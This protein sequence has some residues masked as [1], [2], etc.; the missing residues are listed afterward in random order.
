M[1]TQITA[2][3]I[4]YARNAKTGAGPKINIEH[5]KISSQPT[6][7]VPN[8][9]TLDFPAGEVVYTATSSQLQ[10]AIS[11]NNTV[12]YVLT[13]DESVGPFL[14][15]RIGL[16]TSDGVL[17][18]ITTISATAEYKYK[19]SGNVLGNRL[20]YSIYLS[21]TGLP[22]ICNFT[23]ALL[24]LV[25]VPEVANESLLPDPS[26]VA[27][28]TCQIDRHSIARIPAIALRQGFN[29][30]RDVPAWL[31]ASERRI[32]GQGEGVIPVNAN[33][34]N[35][36]ATVGT[37]VCI[38]Q[39]G[40]QFII[41]DPNV[42]NF[43]V[44]IRSSLEE[45]T[46]YGMYVDP[47]NTYSTLQL[48]Y[49]GAGPN[50]GRI[51]ASPNDWCI[52]YAIGPVN[53]QNA[54]GWLCWIDFTGGLFADQSGTGGGSAT[55]ASGATGAAGPT[56]P[57][58]VIN[59]PGCYLELIN[60]V[61][62][63]HPYNGNSIIINA[64]VQVIPANGV[65]LATTNLIPNTTYYIYA[66]MTNSGMTLEASTMPH[67]TSLITGV[68]IK[69]QDETRSLVGQ[70]RTIAGPAW[71]D[72][73]GQ[74]YVLS[75]FNRRRKRSRSQLILPSNQNRGQITTASGD[76]IELNQ[77]LRNYFLIWGSQL[78]KFTT[79]GS[80]ISLSCGTSTSISFDGGT[81]ELENTAANQ[82]TGG[83]SLYFPIALSG[84]KLG[85]SEGDH[86]S[87]LVGL[88]LTPSG[89]EGGTG[90][91]GGECNWATYVYSN[92]RNLSNPLPAPLSLTITVDG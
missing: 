91:L 82:G 48:L 36:S 66:Y 29:Q 69:S 87:T 44:G 34:F 35:S 55:G 30:G 20:T 73:D 23:I 43:M 65:S 86:Y 37:I 13:L 38:D 81:S 19:T 26:H 72:K 4:T 57:L 8:D 89:S 61:L 17:F 18:S 47:V 2:A 71:S 39:T 80:S 68:E 75:W 31:M 45:I 32:P 70:A 46:N 40:Q 22:Q 24:K 78:A 92:T 56:G 77:T 16:Y 7:P 83:A 14:V 41:G 9:P 6:P 33:L 85:L 5:A 3:G 27:F 88:R 42:T 25:S 90:G 60:N 49:A 15:G 63:L 84:D 21:M 51:V 74:M 50:A 10:Y 79:G 52:G 59:S 28:N 62:V 11:D 58:G 1:A 54:T 53:S 64:Q 67:A 12:E 76:Y